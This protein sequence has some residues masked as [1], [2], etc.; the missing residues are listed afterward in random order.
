MPCEWLQCLLAYSVSHCGGEGAGRGARSIA[1]EYSS[2][3]R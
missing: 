2:M 1:I 3:K